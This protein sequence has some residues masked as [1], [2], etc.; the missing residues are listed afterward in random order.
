MVPPPAGG[1]SV[2]IRLHSLYAL[3]MSVT[4]GRNEPCPCGS[5]N[6][7]KKCCL[8]KDD[9]ARVAAANTAAAAAAAAAPPVAPGA[10]PPQ[11]RAAPAFKPRQ[12]LA[13]TT[14]ARRRSV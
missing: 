14:K 10:A 3:V 7:Y 9:A 5:G 6:K 13:R 2:Y 4:P 1:G 11:Q 12:D 8:E